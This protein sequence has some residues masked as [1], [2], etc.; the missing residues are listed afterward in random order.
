MAPC[1]VQLKPASTAD[2]A[3]PKFMDSPGNTFNRAFV[4]FINSR[5]TKREL[6]LE[7]DLRRW[8]APP[9]PSGPSV[10]EGRPRH[11]LGPGQRERS[12]QRCL[13]ADGEKPDT[14]AGK[15]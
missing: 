3:A 14:R 6:S 7:S 11:K 15:R 8:I 13:P 4:S 5:E 1:G 12:I 2:S 10:T 9:P